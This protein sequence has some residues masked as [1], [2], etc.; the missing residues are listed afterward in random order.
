[1]SYFIYIILGVFPSIVW[2]LF[3][4]RK[5]SHP[6][7]N[8]MILRVFF[9]GAA[10][11]VPAILI[12]LAELE[13]M[14]SIITPNNQTWLLFGYIFLGIALTEEIWKYLMVKWQVFRHSALDEPIDV[15]LYMIIAAL[16]FAAAEN[17][18]VLSGIGDYY[19][20][21]DIFIVSGARLV[22]A[23]F[24]HTLASG[25]LG[26][27]LA[28][29]FLMPEKKTQLTLTG[30]IAAMGLHGLFNLF[31]IELEGYW[32]IGASAFLLIGFGIFLTL[33]FNHVKSMKTVCRLEPVS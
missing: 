18:L 32:R 2:L 16:G 24:L 21:S 26:Y 19:P 30:F 10:S 5:D 25:T 13:Y 17:I 20:L 14:K 9:L 1:M 31:I 27:F 11:T 12:E 7:S 33:A 23:T 8:S 3:Y 6:E 15:V 22:G 4:L 29:S 28:L